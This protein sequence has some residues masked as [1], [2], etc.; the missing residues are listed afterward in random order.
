[1]PPDLCEKGIMEEDSTQPSLSEVRLR[2]VLAHAPLILFCSDIHG[3]ITFS[4]G[5]GLQALGL[6]NDQLVGISAHEIY[7][8]LRTVMPDGTE[9]HARAVFE[10]VIQG[11]SESGD[12]CIENRVYEYKLEPLRD[13]DGTING[14]VGVANDV[15]EL[16]SLEGFRD[17]FIR[18]ASHELRTPLTIAKGYAQLLLLSQDASPALKERL[19]GMERGIE[20]I[21]D[22]V[23]EI[24]N[25]SDVL[26]GGLGLHFGTFELLALTRDEIS[27]A[28]KLTLNHRFVL[29]AGEPV[30]IHGDQKRL[31]KAI[32]YLLH[33]AVSYSP[34]GGDVIVRVEDQGDR[35]EFSVQDFGLGIPK[36]LQHRVFQK[37]FRA[38]G[39]M[40]D[41]YS[42]I[43]VGLYLVSEIIRRHGGTVG[44]ESEQGKGS[45]FFFKLPKQ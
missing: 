31:A 35:I 27:H 41:E 43:G 2:S 36:E 33:N 23:E 20:R 39:S 12:A 37:F 5:K 42:G 30:S 7:G 45:R 24:F 6:R 29:H 38:H 26:E 40:G 28:E 22:V 10:S 21:V 11:N 13:P 17:E 8:N 25:I 3:V 15:T 4:A 19:E 18:I 14:L 16:R 9:S 32:R 44:F 34:R 1:M